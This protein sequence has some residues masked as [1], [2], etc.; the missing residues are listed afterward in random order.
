MCI[1]VFQNEGV[2]V[3]IQLYKEVTLAIVLGSEFAME[4][5]SHPN[6][7]V[8]VIARPATLWYV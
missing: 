1:T 4:E 2:C 7:V 3:Y 6:I 5:L 8:C